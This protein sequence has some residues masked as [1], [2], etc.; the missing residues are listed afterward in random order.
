MASDVSVVGVGSDR[1]A[2]RS[3]LVLKIAIFAVPL[4]VAVAVIGGLLLYEPIVRY[5]IVKKAKERGVAVV[6]GNVDFDWDEAELRN[7]RFALIGVNG[8]EGDI[9][10]AKVKLVDFE[11]VSV[12]AERVQVRIRASATQLALEFGLW[13][14]DH[15]DAFSIPV[16]ASGIHVDW[17]SAVGGKGWLRVD[18]GTISPISDGGVFTSEKTTVA[19]VGIGRVGAVWTKAGTTTSGGVVLGLGQRDLEKA[20]VRVDVTYGSGDPTAKITLRP[21]R[22]SQLALPLGVA[23]PIDDVTVAG[24]ADLSFQGPQGTGKVVGRIDGALLNYVPPHPRELDGIV[25]G[26]RTTYQTELEINPERTLVTLKK[27]VVT[28]GAFRLAGGGTIARKE[29][30]SVIDLDFR[31]AIACTAVA[32]SAANAHLGRGLGGIA[33]RL[34]KP[35]LKGHVAVRVQIKADTSDL[36][37]AKLEPNIGIGCGF[38]GINIELPPFPTNLPPLPSGFPPVPSGIPPIPSTLPTV[39]RFPPAPSAFPK[40]PKFDLPVLPGFGKPPEKKKA[41]D[42]DP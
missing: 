19:G 6:V 9:G 41:N 27:G 32:Q 37:A 23:L 40:L 10:R 3:K 18:D 42:T 39:P 38:K 20:P 14:A 12:D 33:G 24:K 17:A 35:F 31:G 7:V 2:S 21:T 5:M 26:D 15:P 36:A 29:D 1:V 13:T 22:M 4:F 16:N 8:L 34:A 25:F 28:A 11:P 30:S